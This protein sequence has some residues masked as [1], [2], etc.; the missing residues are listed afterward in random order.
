MADS[1]NQGSEQAKQKGAAICGIVM[2]IAAMDGYTE[3]HWAEVLGI[4]KDV[5]KEAGMTG[6]LVS[7][8]EESSLIHSTIV[9]NL[10]DSDV[11]ICDVSGKNPNVMFELGMRLAFD[12]PTL[13]IKDSETTY[14]F[15]T[16][17]VEHIPYPRDLRYPRIVDFKAKLKSKL[18]ATAERAAADPSYSTFL[19]HFQRITVAKLDDKEVSAQE[20]ILRELKSIKQQVA[21]GQRSSAATGRAGSVESVSVKIYNV[22]SMSKDDAEELV[23]Q[24]Q[25]SP[26]VRDCQLTYG[27]N[28]KLLRVAFEGDAPKLAIDTLNAEIRNTINNSTPF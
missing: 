15:D 7:Y 23:Q 16:A 22:E 1:V 12:K 10:F 28:L 9:Q 4:V 18:V 14:S 25:N 17:P 13:I 3:A 5:V 20:Y 26:E 24:L 11:V 8:A 2:P 19:K 6:D 21:D 27:R